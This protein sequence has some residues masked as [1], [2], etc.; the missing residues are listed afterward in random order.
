MA[1]GIGGANM[2]FGCRST[3]NPCV[4]AC[5]MSYDGERRKTALH[6]YPRI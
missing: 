4:K 2:S 3:L 5:I 6:I 1:G